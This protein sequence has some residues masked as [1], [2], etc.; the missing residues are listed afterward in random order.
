[1][2][3]SCRRFVRVFS[4][5]V[6]DALYFYRLGGDK[7]KRF[8]VAT[9]ANEERIYLLFLLKDILIKNFFQSLN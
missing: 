7:M 4:E 8:H 3:F 1:M 9:A 6:P 5:V 2:S